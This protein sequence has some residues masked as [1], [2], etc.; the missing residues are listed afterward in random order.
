MKNPLS[1]IALCIV[2]LCIAAGCKKQDTSANHVL[3]SIND[4]AQATCVMDI[5]PSYDFMG[6]SNCEF[7]FD[8][9]GTF[10][11]GQGAEIGLFAGYQC[12]M[13][14]APL[15]YQTQLF[16]LVA[17]VNTSSSPTIYYS[18]VN[19]GPAD[20]IGNTPG[21]LVLTITQRDSGRI[22]GYVKGT[23][24]RSDV[25]QNLSAG[26]LNCTFDLAIPLVQQ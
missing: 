10:T 7:Q 3:F 17:S 21:N 16:T 14:T 26:S 18:Y 22:Q 12:D 20:S 6:G 24:Y 13:M 1:V 4:S 19:N 23:I 9:L 2:S 25:G 5:R 15:P 8:R 11:G